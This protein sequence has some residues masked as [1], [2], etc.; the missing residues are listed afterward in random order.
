M[1]TSFHE[2]QPLEI[3]SGSFIKGALGPKTYKDK[4]AIGDLSTKAFDIRWRALFKKYFDKE[5]PVRGNKHSVSAKKIGTNVSANT[6]TQNN[7]SNT[8]ISQIV[9]VNLQK[10]SKNEIDFDNDPWIDDYL[11]ENLYY[12][13]PATE[14]ELIDNKVKL[15]LENVK[16]RLLVTLMKWREKMN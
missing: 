16:Q 14:K 1:I 4:N 7:D 10:D 5:I 15:S 11:K 8:Q 9:S 12:S 6:Q 2:V 3:K 13:L